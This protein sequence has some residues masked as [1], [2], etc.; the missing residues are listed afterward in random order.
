MVVDARALVLEIVGA[1]DR[2]V[3]AGV[4]AAEPALLEHRDIG[5]AVLL[6][7]VVGGREPV[8]AGRRR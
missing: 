5:D 4:A 1:D 3:A 7:E 8:A 6:R 2:G